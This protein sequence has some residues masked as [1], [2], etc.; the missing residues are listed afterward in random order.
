M[1]DSS[2]GCL[3]GCVSA[4][5]GKQ[6]DAACDTDAASKTREDASY[7]QAYMTAEPQIEA[8]APQIE[9]AND[10]PCQIDVAKA[11][12]PESGTAAS[13]SL[14]A[15][16]KN[17]LDWLDNILERQD[18]KASA[19]DVSRKL[20]DAAWSGDF[21]G[22]FDALDDGADLTKGFGTY[23]NTAIHVAARTGNTNIL[24]IIL[25]RNAALDVRNK[26]RETPLMGAVRERN[27]GT[28]Q[29]LADAKADLN[30]KD[31]HGNTALSH[32]QH[33]G[34]RGKDFVDF[35]IARGATE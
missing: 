33:H 11:L 13:T 15:E 18:K 28:T 16:E 1:A 31:M 4:L 25:A 23:E 17:A 9:K 20:Y 3:A 32:A 14:G 7:M 10:P 5:C 21:H 26:S 29:M 35:L 8:P 34:E 27:V 2:L 22:A 30:A 6:P 12:L 19:Q 24:K